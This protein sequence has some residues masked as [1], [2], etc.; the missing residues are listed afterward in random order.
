MSA[1]V[2]VTSKMLAGCCGRKQQNLNIHIYC[3]GKYARVNPL[4]LRET[5]SQ[6]WTP[7]NSYC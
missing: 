2:L 6:T 5:L 4:N 1:F 3:L 7:L